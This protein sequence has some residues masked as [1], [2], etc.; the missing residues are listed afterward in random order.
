MRFVFRQTPP[1]H[2]LQMMGPNKYL[3]GPV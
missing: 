3:Y 1:A 2:P